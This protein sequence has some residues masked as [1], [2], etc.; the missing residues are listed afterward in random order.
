MTPPTCAN[1]LGARMILRSMPTPRQLLEDRYAKEE[2]ERR[3]AWVCR[4]K[5]CHFVRLVQPGRAKRPNCS[6][7]G[8]VVDTENH[9]NVALCRRCL[10]R[11]KDGKPRD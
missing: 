2:G 3:R 11:R 10:R 7:C 1:H 5:E 9:F 4:V 6:R 8:Q